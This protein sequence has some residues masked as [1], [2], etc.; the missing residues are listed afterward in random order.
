MSLVATFSSRISHRLCGPRIKPAFTKASTSYQ[1]LRP[2]M[3]AIYGT[4]V[5]SREISFKF[6]SCQVSRMN[7]TW[8]RADC[9]PVQCCFRIWFC[10]PTIEEYCRNRE[11]LLCPNVNVSLSSW[12]REKIYFLI[13]MSISRANCELSRLMPSKAIA[14]IFPICTGRPDFLT[15]NKVKRNLFNC[16]PILINSGPASFDRF[17]SFNVSPVEELPSL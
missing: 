11:N 2:L 12:C 5:R 13:V 17:D 9:V 14:R 3:R 8:V 4:L 7:G 15:V 1:V 6:H 16:R 10:I